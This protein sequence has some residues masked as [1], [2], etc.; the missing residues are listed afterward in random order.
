MNYS[1]A[2]RVATRPNVAISIAVLLATLALA[3]CGNNSATTPTATTTS[4]ASPAPSETVNPDVLQDYSFYFVSDTAQGFRL[5]REVHQVSKIENDLGDDKGL[6]SLLMLVNGQ[7]PPYDGNQVTLWDNGTK[8]NRVSTVDGLATVDLSLGRISFGSESEMRAIDQ[9]VWTLIEND[10]SV[11][12]VQFTIDGQ[13]A[14]SIA[15]HVDLTQPFVQA[16]GYEVLAS[17]W[18]DLLDRSDVMN[19]VSITGSACTFEAN[20]AWELT[21]DGNVV[22]SGATTAAT[23]CPDRSDWTI[24]L[25]DLMPGRYVLTVSDFSAEDGSPIFQDSKAFTVIG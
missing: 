3:G 10:P 20:V 8:V 11:T 1:I 15:G 6:N 2:S 23:A 25:G 18:I 19:P 14:E 21:Q 17:V 13:V 12:S 4:S 5:V 22:D 24:E 9:I 7:L 16:P